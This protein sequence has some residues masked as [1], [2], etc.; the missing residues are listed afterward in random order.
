[1]SPVADP[2][3]IE[4]RQDAVPGG[5]VVYVVGDW[6]DSMRIDVDFAR[7]A[8]EFITVLDGQINIAVQNGIAVYQVESEVNGVMTC[9]LV[10]GTYEP[11]PERT[12]V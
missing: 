5:R 12:L 1:M 3:N 6:P 9:S 7:S 8:G 11:A 10:D 2:R 4:F